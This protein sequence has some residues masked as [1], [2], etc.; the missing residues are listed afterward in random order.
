MSLEHLLCVSD[1]VLLMTRLNEGNRHLLDRRLLGT[2]KPGVLLV[3]TARGGLVDESALVEALESGHVGAA[4]LDVFEVE[5]LAEGHP[6]RRLPNVILTPHAIG[7]TD[8]ALEAIPRMAAAN[9][10]QLLSCQLPASCKNKVVEAGW[11][12]NSGSA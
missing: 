3:N 1:I 7:H 10:E 2:M 12:A 6:L 8:E 9:I 5:P 4:A 11:R